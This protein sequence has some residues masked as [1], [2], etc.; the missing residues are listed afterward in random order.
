M[1]INM[2]S[3]EAPLQRTRYTFIFELLVCA[4]VGVDIFLLVKKRKSNVYTIMCNLMAT[5]SS[6]A[7]VVCGCLPPLTNSLVASH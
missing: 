1:E 4:S 7:Y 3:L 5:N 6:K 2:T